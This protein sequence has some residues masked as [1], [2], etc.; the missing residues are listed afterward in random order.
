M[1][2]TKTLCSRSV[3]GV[4]YKGVSPLFEACIKNRTPLQPEPFISAGVERAG[5]FSLHGFLKGLTP[6]GDVA[7]AS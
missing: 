3:S 6:W 2:P 5:Q 4:G 1:T 7:F